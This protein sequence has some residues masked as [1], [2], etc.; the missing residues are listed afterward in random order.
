MLYKKIGGRGF[1]WGAPN[2]KKTPIFP[3][4]IEMILSNDLIHFL[5]GAVLDCIPIGA[6]IVQR[7]IWG[8]GVGG[9]EYQ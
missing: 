1:F 5:P 2:K 4:I 9:E 7:N 8:D 6:D 3:R